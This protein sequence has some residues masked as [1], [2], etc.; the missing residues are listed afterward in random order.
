MNLTKQETDL[1]EDLKFSTIKNETMYQALTFIGNHMGD[2]HAM[3][4]EYRKKY[5]EQLKK[6]NELVLSPLNDS[7]NTKLG[8]EI[9]K[10][11]NI[12]QFSELTNWFKDKQ[13]FSIL[14][15]TKEGNGVYRI[16]CDS[17]IEVFPLGI[18]TEKPNIVINPIKNNKPTGLFYIYSELCND[19]IFETDEDFPKGKYTID[20]DDLIMEITCNDN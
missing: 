14:L 2:T 11:N 17:G 1:L 12:E 6:H 10:V 20:Y 5:N 9:D 4:I 7:L 15:K 8:K 13:Y 3:T 18:N 19:I 16:S